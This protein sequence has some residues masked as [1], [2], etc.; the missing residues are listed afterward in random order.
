MIRKAKIEDFETVY[1]LIIE[2][3]EIV[4]ID[5]LYGEKEMV[6]NLVEYFYYDE[7]SKISYKNTYVYEIDNVV[8]GCIIAYENKLEQQYNDHMEHVLDN[9][10]KFNVESVEGTMYIDTLSV[11]KSHQRKGIGKLLIN[12]II[13]ST[14]LNISL[15]AEVKKSD[16]ISYYK[17]L[18]FKIIDHVK[19]FD[20]E[21]VILVYEN[22]N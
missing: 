17:N 6:R 19:M 2:A 16:V 12:K 10:Y 18:G 9:G 4:Y 14:T 7:Y 22:T 11:A 1:P 8:V 21:L 20:E 13:E 15:L 3:S 5:A